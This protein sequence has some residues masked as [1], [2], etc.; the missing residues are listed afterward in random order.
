M[1]SKEQ[2][3]KI[4]IVQM[5]AVDKRI[6][7]LRY[8]QA[9]ITKRITPLKVTL[10]QFIQ[11]HKEEIE[12]YIAHDHKFSM[13]AWAVDKIKRGYFGTDVSLN[14]MQQIIVELANAKLLEY[15]P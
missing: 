9:Q 13:L 14:Q 2:K 12:V 1:K 5:L 11:Q 10:R 4:T 7:T 8:K 3:R 15:K 6:Y